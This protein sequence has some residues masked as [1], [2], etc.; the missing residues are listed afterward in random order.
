MKKYLV[1]LLLGLGM[2]ILN[3]T[4]WA[5]TGTST[6]ATDILTLM[7]D[8]IDGPVGQAVAL[9]LVA[10][11]AA[12]M[13]FRQP[14]AGVLALVSGGVIALAPTIVTGMGAMLF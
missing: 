14:M 8:I 4:V 3:Q 7:T 9:G 2:V 10:I 11:G 13:V 5:F 12:S 1:A 6:F